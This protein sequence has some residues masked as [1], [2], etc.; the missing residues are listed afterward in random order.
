M[1]ARFTAASSF[2]R[3]THKSEHT[4]LGGTS[5]VELNSTLGH[6]GLLIEG[7]P[8]EV[9]GTVAEVTGEFSAGDVLHDGKLQEANEGKNLEGTGNGDGE[10]G[11]PAVSEVRELGA[12]VVNVTG[13]VDSGG[14]D[15]VSD[16]TKHTDTSVLDL[17]ISEAVELLL[18]TISDKAEGIE[19][20]KRGL[21]TE[22][23]FEGVEGR[24][25]GLLGG[26]GESGGRGDEGGEDSGLHDDSMKIVRIFVG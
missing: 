1:I 13:K 20:A 22:L 8:A 18:V 23:T 5:L 2:C 16:N 11:I 21:G 4:H 12:G 3:L 10:G 9:K 7:V 6:L 26:R 24:G 19:E 17:D 15:K 25:G 14:V